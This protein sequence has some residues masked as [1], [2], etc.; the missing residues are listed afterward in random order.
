MRSTI[1]FGFSRSLTIPCSGF[2]AGLEYTQPVQAAA[3]CGSRAGHRPRDGRLRTSSSIQAGADPHVDDPLEG[4][5]HDGAA[6]GARRV[7]VRG[8]SPARRAGRVEPCGRVPEGRGREHPAR[9]RDPRQHGARVSPGVRRVRRGSW[10]WMKTRV[11][12]ARHAEE[13][14]TLQRPALVRLRALDRAQQAPRR[15]LTV[16][17]GGRAGRG[18]V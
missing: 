17:M 2:T 15:R 14:R 5:A 12:R 18:P 9:A 4:M 1:V 16:G 13:R 3:S 7:R 11:V 8:A 10:R 6:R